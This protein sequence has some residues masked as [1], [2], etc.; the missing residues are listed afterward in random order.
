MAF[1]SILVASCFIP[2]GSLDS[3]GLFQSYPITSPA[4]PITNHHT[5]IYPLP[6]SKHK[7]YIYTFPLCSA[8]PIVFN[9]TV[10]LNS[11]KPGPVA[12]DGTV[13]AASGAN[14]SRKDEQMAMAA[15]KERMKKIPPQVRLFV[16]SCLCS[17]VLMFLCSY[18]D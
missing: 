14:R 10:G 3:S 5:D 8:R 17:Y 11:S 1:F 12:A 4:S 6:Y 16:R 2:C 9:Q 7:T 18:V 13:A 15:E